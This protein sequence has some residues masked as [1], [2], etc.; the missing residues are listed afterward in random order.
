M[1][2]REARVTLTSLDRKVDGAITTLHDKIDT[3]VTTLHDKIDTSVT[4]LHDKID[5]SADRL[6]MRIDRLD[7][8]FDDRFD[9]AMRHARVLN[10][11]TRQEIRQVAEVLDGLNE[12]VSHFL[13][14]SVRTESDVEL[15]KIASR[16][17]DRRVT[18]L[19]EAPS[20]TDR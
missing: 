8:K 9:E 15:L 6:D 7:R 17:L 1:V 10:E 19:E 11:H 14:R 18:D 3:S 2:K 13:E 5:T 20:H 12:K 4:T 16:G